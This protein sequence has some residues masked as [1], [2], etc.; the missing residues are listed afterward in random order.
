LC[1]PESY[2]GLGYQNL[3]SM[4]FRLIG[5]RDA[6]MQVGKAAAVASAAG[7]E[8]IS[9]PPLHLVLVEEPEAHLHAQVQQVFIRKA[10]ELL[11]DHGSLGK[12]TK[13]STQLV[14]ST[15]SSHVAHECDFSCIRYFRRRPSSSKDEVP[16]ATV[17]NLSE[18]FGDVSDTQRFVT[19]Y[20]KVTHCDLFFAD[21]AILIEGPAERILVPHFISRDQE[22][23][24]L[25]QCYITLLEIGGSHAH[26]L[27]TLI[28]QLGLITLVVTDLDA[29]NPI[30]DTAV[31]PARGQMQVSR[32]ATL[33][34]WI[35]RK[36]SLDDLL[37]LSAE[38]KVEKYDEFFSVR[39]AYQFPVQVPLKGGSSPV[40]IVPNTFEDALVYD[41]LQVFRSLEGTSSIKRFKETVNKDSTAAELAK[42]MFTILK[43][44]KK[45]EFAL[46]L[47][48]LKQ[49]PWP[50]VCPAY[51]REG[52]LWLQE[53]IRQKQQETLSSSAEQTTADPVSK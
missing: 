53:R 21:A 4:V 7:A 51:I 25:S 39:V 23:R 40:E 44:A 43:T 15:H 26:R 8:E 12:N 3:I 32:N 6:W 20:L 14:V 24:G 42:E 28:E 33:N 30:D 22:L 52:L 41:N 2:N 29:M 19:R 5:F 11:R 50:I 35:P 46:D 45:A 48:D 31:T 17:V 38:Q 16:T 9:P 47:L 18:V 37:D 36:N 1:L 34:S 27:R 49:E 13:L 10:Y